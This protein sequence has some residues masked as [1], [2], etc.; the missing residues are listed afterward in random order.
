M[1][2]TFAAAIALWLHSEVLALLSLSHRL[3]RDCSMTD[4]TTI[5]PEKIASKENRWKIF[6]ILTGM[7]H[8]A[9]FV[10]CPNFVVPPRVSQQIPKVVE[11]EVILLIP[12]IWSMYLLFRY[13]TLEERV[14]GWLSL[15][16]SLLWLAHAAVLMGM[17]QYEYWPQF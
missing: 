6:L 3:W 2:L 11:A 12:F 17:T 14:V 16:V 8:I 1:V 10:G 5:K 13:R 4:S 9:V 15:G 7:V